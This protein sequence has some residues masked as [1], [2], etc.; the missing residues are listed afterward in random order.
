MR[1]TTKIITGIILAT[2]IILLIV[3][4]AFSFSDRKNYHKSPFNYE[5]IAASQDSKIEMNVEPYKVVVLDKDVAGQNEH[6]YWFRDDCLVSFNPVTTENE[7]NK[8]LIPE[9][10]ADFIT[11][12]TLNDTLTIKVKLDDLGQK[13]ET[14]G[15]EG[16]AISGIR[17]NL[18]TSTV[19]VINKLDGGFLTEIRNIKTDDIKVKAESDVSLFGCEANKVTILKAKSINL[20]NS[21]LKELNFDYSKSW[22]VENCKIK[23]ESDR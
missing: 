1:L 20:E 6:T 13:Y 19:D 14:T 9:E 5:L 21:K 23:V 8:L 4:I 7:S 11:A 16:I 10:F 17:L 15:K 18:H 12:N 3:I 2:F 22:K